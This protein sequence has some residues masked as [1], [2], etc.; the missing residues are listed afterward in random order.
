MSNEEKDSIIHKIYYGRSG[1]GSPIRTYKDAKEQLNS[2]TYAYTRDW[3][4]RTLDR[5]KATC[6]GKNTFSV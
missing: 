4:K 2:I 1:F 6:G 5:T 3:F